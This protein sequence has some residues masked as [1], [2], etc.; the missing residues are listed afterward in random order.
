M[1]LYVL[2]Y[3]QTQSS[4]FVHN[5]ACWS[6]NTV[7]QRTVIH[8]DYCLPYNS[9]T[10]ESFYCCSVLRNILC[11]LIVEC[12]VITRIWKYITR[13]VQCPNEGHS[14]LSSTSS[15]IIVIIIIITIIIHYYLGLDRSVSA[16]S[17]SLLQVLKI[18]FAHSVY[19]SEL[20]LPS[21]CCSFLLTS[22]HN[23]VC[24][25]FFESC[26]YFQIFQIS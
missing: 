23:L 19:N 5:C 22:P 10:E 8:F 25:L 1:L 21:C 18:T 16:F 12:K 15:S 20:F 6:L 4:H 14:K 24:I 7:Y 3:F 9:P 17:N 13:K 26:Y 2:W 11:L